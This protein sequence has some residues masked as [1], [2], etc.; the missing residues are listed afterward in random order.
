MLG[1][2]VCILS[3]K[4]LSEFQQ[5]LER[6]FNFD[7]PTR[8]KKGIICA[9][10]KPRIGV[11]VMN[12][13]V[14]MIDKNCNLTSACFSGS[15][16]IWGPCIE[17]IRNNSGNGSAPLK[18]WIKLPLE[19]SQMLKNLLGGQMHEELKHNFIP[20]AFIYMLPPNL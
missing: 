8:I 6:S 4:E 18:S 13:H 7:D 14:L 16:L 5:H 9:R 17:M 19:F 15:W 1:G 2:Y 11:W 20:S 3:D 12:N 10:K